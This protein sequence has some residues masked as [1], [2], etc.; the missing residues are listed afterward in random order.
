MSLKQYDITNAKPRE[1]P[2]KLAYGD[3]LH[4]LVN[5]NGSKLWRLKYRIG[6]KEKRLSIG[7]FPEVSIVTARE[8]T[9]DARKLLTQGIDPSQK[10]KE[11][12][13]A[14]GIAAANTFGAIGTEYQAKLKED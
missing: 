14:A 1:K 5:P 2:Y 8:K 6:G 4:V 7:P 3:G 13:I 11:E 10:R 9:A 12:K